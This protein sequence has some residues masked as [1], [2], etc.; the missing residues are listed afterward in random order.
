MQ[1]GNFQTES[2]ER[3]GSEIKTSSYSRQTSGT[4]A[5]YLK[6]IRKAPLLTADAEKETGMKVIA[7]DEEA[8]KKMISANLRLVVK[9]AKKYIN[10]DLAFLDLIE[11]GN[12]G[13][14]KAV[15][16]F[17]PTRGYRFS[18]YATW[19]IRQSIE[20]AI[21]NQ[22]RVVRLPVHISD[23]IN[24]MLKTSKSLTLELK[25]EPAPLEIAEKMQTTVRN[26]SKLSM[27][28]KKASSLDNSLDKETDSNFDYN[29]ND[30]LV[31]PSQKDPSHDVEI[32]GR[33][34]E[35]R[36]WLSILNDAER[37]IIEMRFGM[38]AS[39]EYESMTLE[40][41]GKLFGVTR[42]RIRQIEKTAIE[43]LRKYTGKYHIEIGDVI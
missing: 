14:I 38:D 37:R 3:Y 29:L 2:Y 43:K 20:R 4:L 23:E 26:I 12:I 34:M 21:I 6:E 27:L 11:E 31:D 13:L 8:V 39:C 1:A 24:R 25:R 32:H 33:N 5:I 10:R 28:I 30:I 42:E 7:G 16:K 35:I 22:S 9:I 36:R 19:W 40:R 17:D 41:I 15:H 18:T